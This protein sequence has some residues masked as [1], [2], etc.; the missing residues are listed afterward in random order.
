MEFSAKVFIS[1]HSY[2]LL[3]FRLPHE[4]TNQDIMDTNIATI[5]MHLL[6]R[7]FGNGSLTHKKCDIIQIPS[8][9][10]VSR[11][12]RGNNCNLLQPTHPTVQVAYFSTH[13]VSPVT[14]A[15]RDHLHFVHRNGIVGSC[16]NI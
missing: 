14:N 9:L 15:T 2:S 4:K 10:F 13:L 11:H 8:H 12:I 3:F 5:N 16:I 7:K 1:V 6:I